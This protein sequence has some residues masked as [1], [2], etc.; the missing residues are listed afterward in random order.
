MTLKE[1]VPI[2]TILNGEFLSFN[3]LKHIKFEDDIIGFVEAYQ[4]SCDMN[5][6]KVIRGH[7]YPQ[8]SGNRTFQ[9]TYNLAGGT[10]VGWKKKEA[11]LPHVFDF[12]SFDV[13]GSVV[14]PPKLVDDY[15]S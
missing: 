8:G 9:G 3:E 14:K 7:G 2:N 1:V 6:Q 10:G 4:T 13:D 15:N 5:G 12:P 11:F